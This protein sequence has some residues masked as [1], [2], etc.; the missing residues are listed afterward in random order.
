MGNESN[1]DLNARQNPY[2]KL[3]NND[4]FKNHN[5]T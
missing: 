1:D 4:N 3:L 2:R 5:L